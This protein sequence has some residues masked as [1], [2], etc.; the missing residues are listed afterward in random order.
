MSCSILTVTFIINIIIKYHHLQTEICHRLAYVWST[1]LSSFLLEHPG[2]PE[3]PL[4]FLI[5]RFCLSCLWGIISWLRPAVGSGA[6]FIHGNIMSF[7]AVVSCEGTG[8]RNRC[9]HLLFFQIGHCVS[10]PSGP[11][12]EQQSKHPSS[13]QKVRIQYHLGVPLSLWLAMESEFRA[14]GPGPPWA[15][16]SDSVQPQP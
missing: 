2:H 8:D 15:V 1:G 6:A 12:V 9:P 11:G 14:L 4:C 13:P 3:L 10:L 7:Q 16:Y 5:T